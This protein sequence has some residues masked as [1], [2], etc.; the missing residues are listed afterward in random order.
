MDKACFALGLDSFVL[1]LDILFSSSNPCGINLFLPNI[2]KPQIH[3]MRR[4]AKVHA[5]LGPL[6]SLVHLYNTAFNSL[7]RPF[8]HHNAVVLVKS[9]QR[10][11]NL[12][13]QPQK[14]LNNLQIVPAQS[15]NISIAVQKV[16]K[17]RHLLKRRKGKFIIENLGSTPSGAF[18]P[19]GVGSSAIPLSLQHPQ[20]RNPP[21]PVASLSC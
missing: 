21:L 20:R 16:I 12:R 17:I 18:A 9:H 13:P 5:D 14:M 4:P 19:D 7:K 6:L 8:N 10:L 2:R 3:S 15:H 1:R 11:A